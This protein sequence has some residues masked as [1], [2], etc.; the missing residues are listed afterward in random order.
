LG[1]RAL[2][3]FQVDAFTR[4]RFSGNPAT[5]VLD[6]EGLADPALADIAREFAH[7]EV[8]FVLPPADTGHDLRIRFFNAR[9]EAPFVGHATLAAHAVLLELGRRGLGVCRQLSGTGVVAVTAERDDADPSG[10]PALEFQQSAPELGAPLPFKTS[11]RVAEAL[12]LAGERLHESLPVRV[13]RIGSARLLIPLADAPALDALA[14]HMDGLTTL[15]RELGVEGFFAFAFRRD[16]RG[17]STD[18]RMFCPALGIPED[19]VSGNAHAMLAAY[20]YDVGLIGRGKT[21]FT[22][23]QGAQIRRPGQVRVRI[24]LAQGRLVAVRIGGHAV[25][26]SEGRL[27]S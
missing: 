17:A 19:P 9:K 4:N 8:A 25:I 15:G 2:R 26:V 20:L 24:D 12:G 13:G 21:G 1:H 10:P 18:S 11:L 22:G 6:A 7:A 23:R 14:P 3:I 27:A 5:V 16:P